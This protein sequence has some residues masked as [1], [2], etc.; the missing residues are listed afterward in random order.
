MSPLFC[1]TDFVLTFCGEVSEFTDDGD[2]VVV[3]GT[4][5]LDGVFANANGDDDADADGDCEDGVLCVDDDVSELA[6]LW[7]VNELVLPRAS[8]C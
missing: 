5:N 1:D 8:A 3:R 7:P 2:C 6:S 4:H